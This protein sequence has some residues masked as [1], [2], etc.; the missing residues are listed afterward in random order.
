MGKKSFTRAPQGFMRAS[1]RSRALSIRSLIA[2]TLLLAA[3]SAH[4]K[5]HER[6]DEYEKRTMVSVSSVLSSSTVLKPVAIWGAWRPPEDDEVRMRLAISSTEPMWLGCESVHVWVDGDVSKHEVDHTT[7]ASTT[8]EILTGLPGHK[9]TEV[10]TFDVS[11]ALLRQIIQADAARV[12]VCG[13]EYQFT[14]DNAKDLLTFYR[15]VWQG[16]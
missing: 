9:Q 10:I 11:R 6:Y 12:A 16:V 7:G 3:C 2:T 14:T 13:R 1:T 8:G 4:G 15:A 5:V